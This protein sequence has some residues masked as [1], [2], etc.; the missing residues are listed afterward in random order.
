MIGCLISLPF[1]P[2][3]VCRA[4]FP[5]LPCLLSL[6]VIYTYLPCL[7]CLSFA[8][9]RDPL[10]APGDRS[11]H[12][13]RGLLAHGHAHLRSRGYRDF[14]VRPG[15][16]RVFH[17]VGVSYRD[18][19]AQAPGGVGFAQVDSSCHLVRPSQRGRFFCA[20]GGSKT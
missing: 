6:Y 12:P 4:C 20:G 16:I 14:P 10:A 8:A 2:F 15:P 18:F 5:C 17:C 1:P 13:V 11:L 7:S 9:Y 19:A 3:L